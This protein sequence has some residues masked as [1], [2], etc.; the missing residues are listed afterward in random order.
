M[1]IIWFNDF[2]GGLVFTFTTRNL[3]FELSD[4]IYTSTN[5][6]INSNYIILFECPEIQIFLNKTMVFFCKK[7]FINLLLNDR[8]SKHF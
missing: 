1:K 5:C 8:F 6:D 3:I 2:L 4:V 7:K